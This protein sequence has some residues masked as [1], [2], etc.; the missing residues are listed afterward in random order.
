MAFEQMSI[1]DFLWQD[2]KVV[3]IERS[4]AKEFIERI[5]YSRKLP[6]NVV[7]CFGMY[8]PGGDL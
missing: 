4:I 3:R 8:E 6:S 5:H 2:R 7:Y 1:D